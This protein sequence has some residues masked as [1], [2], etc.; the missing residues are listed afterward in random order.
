VFT[1]CVKPVKHKITCASTWH[2]YSTPGWSGI[3][4]TASHHGI[5]NPG[6]GAITASGT[7]MSEPIFTQQGAFSA[8]DNCYYLLQNDSLF[9][10]DASGIVT[11]YAPADTA[12]RCV[13]VLYNAFNHGLY[14]YMNGGSSG[15]LAQ[16]SIG[17]TTYSAT[18]SATPTHAVSYQLFAPANIAVDNTT[19]SMYLLTSSLSNYYVEKYQ[20]GTPGTTV[21]ASGS[22]VHPILEMRFNKNDGKLYAITLNA[23]TVSYD[24]LKID[25]A[26]GSVTHVANIGNFVNCDMYSASFDACNNQ[27][28][29]STSIPGSIFSYGIYKLNLA[30]SV[31]ST[32]TIS[33]LYQGLTIVDY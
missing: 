9:K 13:S 21:V 27:Y 17:T 2:A 6:T 16:L 12:H 8:T 10:M 32:D 18:L 19:G 1:G 23:D 4:Y 20:P 14:C 30:G 3:P 26:A 5:I 28:I 11:K 29:I 24:F 31:T 15:A 25:P 22:L 33:S 7:F